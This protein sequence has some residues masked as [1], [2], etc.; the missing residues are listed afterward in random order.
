M[1]Y[2]YDIKNLLDILCNYSYACWRQNH[3]PAVYQNVLT[4]R[5]GKGLY[6][7]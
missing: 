7:E 5:M 6:D 4:T 2:D 3:V 1:S